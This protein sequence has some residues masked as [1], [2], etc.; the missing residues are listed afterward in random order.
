MEL[1]GLG[2]TWSTYPKKYQTWFIKRCFDACNNTSSQSLKEAK[3]LNEKADNRIIGLTLETRPDYIDAKEL[4]RMRWLGCTRVELGVQSI[5]DDILKYNRRDHDIKATIQATKFLKNAGFKATYHIM[6]NL[7]KSN[8]AKDLE[9]FTRLFSSAD[10]QPDQLK[11]YPCAVLKT[12]PLYK[13]WQK[14]GY[15]PYSDKQLT[16]LLIKIKKK[17]PPYVRIIRVI[18]DIPSQSIVAGSKVSNLR[19]IISNQTGKICQCIRCREPQALIAKKLKLFRQDYQSADG[20]EVFLSFEDPQ[21]KNLYAFLR[22][23]ITDSWTLPVLKDAA[24]IRELHTYGKVIEL[25]KK[26]AKA[27]QH[28]GLGK[29]L[30]KEAERITQKEF[31]LS[32][33]AVISGVGVREYYRQLG[34]QLKDEYMFKYLLPR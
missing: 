11:I 23:R 5:Y 1:I 28:R 12:A 10:F 21:R 25:N 7:P 3:K 13:I 9:M 30:M 16:N 29:K 24:L 34:Y 22:L 14:G 26:S 15:V 8:P 18:R 32:K 4:K 27:S 17:I 33:I 19:Q 20:R 6:L 31:K 2:G